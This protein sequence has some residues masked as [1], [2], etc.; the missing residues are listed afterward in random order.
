MRNLQKY[1]ANWQRKTFGTNKKHWEGLLNHLRKEIEELEDSILDYH[2]HEVSAIEAHKAIENELADCII[3][4]VGL[5]DA[6]KI[7]L[8]LATQKKMSENLNRKWK[9][10]DKHGVCEHEDEID[11]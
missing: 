1:I 6:F 8:E 7:D 11:D 3:L 9:K 5:A 10:P 4:L 2:S